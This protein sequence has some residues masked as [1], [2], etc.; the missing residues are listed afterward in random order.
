MTRGFVTCTCRQCGNKFDKIKYCANRRDAD[1]WES[2]AK[3][4]ITL[5]YECHKKEQNKKLAEKRD[6][7]AVL[8]GSEKQIAWAERIR[9]QFV[10]G[11]DKA[12]AETDNEYLPL[13]QKV[14]D[15]TKSISSAAWWIDHRDFGDA[16]N[17]ANMV[18]SEHQDQF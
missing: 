16:A 6:G 1:S 11:I 17:L 8:S 18:L 3:S 7:L 4:N 2:W 13:L 14:I 5:C 12:I 15:Y 10:A 9:D